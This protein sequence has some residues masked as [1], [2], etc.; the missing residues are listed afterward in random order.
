MR[1]LKRAISLIKKQRHA[2]LVSASKNIKDA[3][4]RQHDEVVKF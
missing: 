2:E 3:D 1:K 4:I